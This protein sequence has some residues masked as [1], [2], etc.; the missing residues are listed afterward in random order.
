MRAMRIVTVVVQHNLKR[1]RPQDIADVVKISNKLLHALKPESNTSVFWSGTTNDI[2][3][4]CGN[5]GT[6]ICSILPQRDSSYG[7]S[8]ARDKT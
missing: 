5:Q 1:V 7:A 2:C 4:H 8:K 3:V 6:E